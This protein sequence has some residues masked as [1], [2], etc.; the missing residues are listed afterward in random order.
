MLLPNAVTENG[1]ARLAQC[2]DFLEELGEQAAHGHLTLPERVYWA[3]LA[4]KAAVRDVD[5]GRPL[6]A[7]D[8]AT[9]AAGMLR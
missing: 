1:A 6:E 2:P 4:L 9:F 8:L 5:A 3:R 7:A